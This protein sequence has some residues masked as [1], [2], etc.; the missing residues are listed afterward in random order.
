MKKYLLL[1][2]A[3]FLLSACASNSNKPS[4][5][6]DS[7]EDVSENSEVIESEEGPESQESEPSISE[8]ESETEA[9]ND[10]IL[11]YSSFPAQ[12]GS[13]YPAD[14]DITSEGYSFHVSNCCQNTGK[15]SPISV[16][17]MRKQNAYFYNTVALNGKLTIEVMV[18]TFTDYQNGGVEVDA[19]ICPTIYR[20]STQSGL[21]SA[22]PINIT[23][24]T[25]NEEGNI[26]TFVLNT[27]SGVSYFKLANESS[28]AQYIRSVTWSW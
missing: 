20:A 11:D 14:Q 10:F 23:Q 27:E 9:E 2:S 1:F 17:Q 18:N 12:T 22:S 7:E 4:D 15:F 8:E 25:L 16:I 19:T 28:Y 5:T 6:S 26:K 24:G 3:L 21:E 13:G